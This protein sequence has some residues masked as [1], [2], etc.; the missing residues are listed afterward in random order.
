MQRPTIMRIAAVLAFVFGIPLLLAP[1]ML[2]AVYRSS[3]LNLPGVYQAMLHGA[4]LLAF[5]TMNWMAARE[6]Y[7]V[8]RPVILGTLLFTVL[9]SVVALV[10]QLAGLAPPAAWLN[11]GIYLVLAGAYARMMLLGAGEAAPELRST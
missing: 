3:E 6:P 11:V 9:G 5:G 7:A 4:C 2:M 10:R 1:N 8:V